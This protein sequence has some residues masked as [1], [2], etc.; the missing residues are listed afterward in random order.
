[1]YATRAG[2]QSPPTA[3]IGGVTFCTSH[4]LLSPWYRVG[5]T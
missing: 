5:I 1:M 2:V 3:T 4:R